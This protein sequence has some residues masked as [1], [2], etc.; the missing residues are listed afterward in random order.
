MKLERGIL[1]YIL[2]LDNYF[3]NP[4]KCFLIHGCGLQVSLREPIRAG[5]DDLGLK[6]IIGAAVCAY[7]RLCLF[8]L[9]FI[10]V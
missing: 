8:S 3:C 10:V 2:V 5:I 1:I 7:A 4:K 6:Q 9:V